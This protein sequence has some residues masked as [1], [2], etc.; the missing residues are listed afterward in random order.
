MDL[1]RRLIEH[2]EGKFKG[3]FTRRSD[4]WYYVSRPEIGLQKRGQNGEKM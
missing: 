2:N 1:E 4:D 3:C